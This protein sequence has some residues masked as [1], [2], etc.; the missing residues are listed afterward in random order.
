MNV[1]PDLVVSAFLDIGESLAGTV[2][3]L[4]GLDA[5][6]FAR[7]F[8]SLAARPVAVHVAGDGESFRQALCFPVT[9]EAQGDVIQPVT[10]V[11]PHVVVELPSGHVICL[12]LADC[13]SGRFSLGVFLRSIERFLERIP[14]E[15]SSY[16]IDIQKRIE[17]V[18]RRRVVLIDFILEANET[19]FWKEYFPAGNS[20]LMEAALFRGMPTTSATGRKQ[21]VSALA[22]IQS[23]HYCNAVKGFIQNLDGEVIQAIR[24][25]GLPPS[26]SKY[27]TYHR[28]DDA[29]T[30]YRVQAAKVVPLLGYLL[31]EE[32][33]YAIRLRRLVDDGAPLW[34][35]L[36]DTVGVP[37]ETARWLRGKTADDVSDAWLGRIPEL[38]MSLSHL[39][40]EK[41]PKT[42]DE[43]TAYTDFALVLN[44]KQAQP[45]QARWLQD[46]GRLGWIA[47]RD[48]FAAMGAAPS[49]LLD[50]GDLLHEVVGAVGGE[51]L[52]HVARRWRNDR[53]DDP[54]WRRMKEAVETLFLETSVLKQMRA[55]LRWHE[56]QL[57]PHEE[58]A[59]IEDENSSDEVKPRLDQ[60]PA[61]LTHPFKIGSLTAHFLMTS[62]LLRDEGHRME[63]CVGSYSEHCLFN[64]SNIVS[65][66]TNDDGRSVSTAE[67]QLVDYGK[68]MGFVLIQHKARRNGYPSTEAA[69]ALAR[70]LLQ[71]NTDEMQPRL[72][73]MKE[74]L[75]ERQALD[76]TRSLWRADT[77]LAPHRLKCLKAALKLHIGYERFRA[78]G[79]NTIGV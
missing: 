36:A 75:K 10:S 27:N 57:L 50:V 40:P 31:G 58:E 77:P 19:V 47:A 72:L 79:Q 13:A 12:R 62:A 11:A 53:E 43:W 74:Q 51:L 35:A 33:H 4:R 71:L 69:D 63:H 26:V 34:P 21:A 48:K 39:F 70:L 60:W 54:E 46:L 78:A 30:R 55:S 44:Q 28:C 76:D 73:K 22:G 20:K 65:L 59:V 2:L 52:P 23:E 41:R 67:L 17:M 5:Q 61:P 68:R 56:L 9:G 42:R 6:D 25:S 66:R 7:Q 29:V 38:M 1:R 3:H 15:T 16:W 45:Y 14:Q 32:T 64:G 37:E 24:A 49:D 8:A 18:V